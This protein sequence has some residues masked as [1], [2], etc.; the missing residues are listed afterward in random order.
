[1]SPATPQAYRPGGPPDSDNCPGP[2]WDKRAEGTIARL[3]A[4]YDAESQP[5]RGAREET[6]VGVLPLGRSQRLPL[7]S[8]TSYVTVE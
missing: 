1:M 8:R 3:L 4:S 2:R 5:D 6:S 7:I